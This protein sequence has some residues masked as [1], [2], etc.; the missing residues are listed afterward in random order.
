[1]IL[2]LFTLLN[3]IACGGDPEPTIVVDK[4]DDTYSP[5]KVKPVLD[6]WQR[7]TFNYFYEG[8]DPNSGMAYEGN[9]RGPP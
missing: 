8:A 9:E 4:N 5:E 6:E 2:I 1:M 3:I 7:K